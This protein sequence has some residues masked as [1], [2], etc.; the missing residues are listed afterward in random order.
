M[1]R[2]SPMNTPTKLQTHTV[3][4]QSVDTFAVPELLIPR[5]AKEH[6]YNIKKAERLLKEAKRMLWLSAQFNQPVSPSLEID[7]AWHEMLMFTR[8]YQNFSHHIGNF[9]HHDP[10][11]GV[12]DGGACYRATKAL[13]KEKIG[14]EP[15]TDLWP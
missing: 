2:S 14:E 3:T 5:I 9:I 15:P 6:N 10:T 11:P 1:L 8:F 12:P 4:V 13:Y 7:D